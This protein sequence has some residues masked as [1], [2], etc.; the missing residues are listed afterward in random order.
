MTAPDLLRT[1]FD[2][3]RD[4]SRQ[5]VET[6][7]ATRH[8]RLNRLA[9]ILLENTNDIINAI[10]ADFG[11]RVH[12]ET[13]L[14][15]ILP[16]LNALRH[17]RRH[18]RGWMR[19]RRRRI[20]WHFWP[21]S[22]QLLPQ[23]LGVVG[24]MA[25]WNYPLLLTLG[26]LVDALAAGNRAMLKPSELAPRYS[27]LLAQ[28]VAK[29]FA[30]DEVHVVTGGVET[31]QAFAA[32]P[33]DHL[34]FTGST[35]V[36]R[37]VAMAAAPNLTPV[38][39]ELGG[40][41]P[42]IVTPGANLDRAARSLAFGKFLNAGQ[43][44]IAPDHVYVPRSQ[45]DDLSQKI[46]QRTAAAYPSLGNNFTALISQAHF[47]R[48]QALLAALPADT[49]IEQIGRDAPDARK[50]APRLVLDP[51]RDTPLMTEEIFGPILPLVPYDDLQELLAHQNRGE[52][53][54]ALYCFTSGHA[55]T[56][57]IT[58]AVIA[59]GMTTNGTILH[60]AQD[61]LP[62]GGVGASGQGAYHGYD[63]FRRLSHMM[64]V[65]NIGFI[66]AFERIGPPWG[67]LARAT[68]RFL[69]R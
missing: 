37:K 16:A 41:S 2:T 26:P 65:Y 61:N 46:V 13:R 67:R 57:R 10:D 55:E 39:L 27:D 23:P 52:R 54:L 34:L 32:L 21:S 69:T 63:G 44:C 62:F 19:P 4:A 50:L 45:L 20:S 11:G 64:P 38:T 14:L 58:R 8:D 60:I 59:G 56:R 7:L 18:V 24:I 25:P 66:N 1:A 9:S 43:T 31:A 49:R 6:D 47:D 17:A 28:I 51:P 33:F 3:M 35:A 42:V 68:Y 12:D 29:T 30:P 22:G 5:S 48:Q 53:P 36:G 15:E 40:K